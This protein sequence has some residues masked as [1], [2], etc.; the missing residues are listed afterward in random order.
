MITLWSRGTADDNMPESML[1]DTM[2]RV[3]AHP[4]SR[5]RAKLVLRVLDQAGIRAPAPVM[6]VGCGWGLNLDAL[7]R[8][9]YAADGMDISRQVLEAIDVPARRLM[10]A[11]L[12]QP[13]PDGHPLYDALLALDVIEHIDDDTA[14][15]RRMAELLNPGGLAIISVPALPDLYSEFDR[16]Q[17]H[18][19]RYVP[20]TLRGAVEGAGL[21]VERIFWWGAWMVPILRAMRRKGKEEKARTYADYWKMPPWPA[22]LVFKIAYE[23]EE[24]RALRGTLKTGTSLFAVARTPPAKP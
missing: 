24:K 19:R 14:A 18:R 17:G 21:T 9:G 11:D 8:A 10:E 1:V 5:A 2:K 6:E 22:P 4:W 15:V 16:I 3:W 23:L 13:L 12:T 7:E 20:E